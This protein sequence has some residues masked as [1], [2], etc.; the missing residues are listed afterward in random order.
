MK[1]KLIELIRQVPI[2]G[3]TYEEYVEA[4]ADKLISVGK[5]DYIGRD[6]WSEY[7]LSVE[8]SKISAVSFDGR[9]VE[10]IAYCFDGEEFSFNESDIGKEVFF[11][12]EDVEKVLGA[13]KAETKESGVQS[14][15]DAELLKNAKI[16]PQA[17][18]SPRDY[19]KTIEFR[20]FENL[21]CRK[22]FENDQRKQRNDAEGI[23]HP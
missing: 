14:F 4:L 13:R 3:K 17:F 2:S 5:L 8:K 23:R 19:G 10:F 18:K 7:G 11:T 9:E 21:K 16:N 1:E 12:K 22:E 15:Y 20:K 6:I